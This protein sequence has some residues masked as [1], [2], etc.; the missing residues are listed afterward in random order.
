MV[1]RGWKGIMSPS[2]MQACC[3]LLIVSWC[4]LLSHLSL[5][6]EAR[7]QGSVLYV[8]ELKVLTVGSWLKGNS[9]AQR[10]SSMAAILSKLNGPLD[11]AMVKDGSNFRIVAGP[12]LLVLVTPVEAKA[13]RIGI[14][15]PAQ[16]WMSNIQKALSLPPLQIG[17]DDLRIV[18][19]VPKF[20]RLIGTA[21]STA[22]FASS[23]AKVLAV[24][25]VPGGLSLKGLTLGEATVTVASGEYLETIV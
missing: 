7:A 24:K 15:S 1:G 14:E 9:P 18:P 3:K 8:N 4:L 13:H 12:T 6:V 21:A 20:V 11:L 2:Q 19:G 23:N 25:R 17:Q 5:A 22:L 16:N 10:A